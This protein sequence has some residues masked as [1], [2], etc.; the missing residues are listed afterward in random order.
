VLLTSMILWMALKGPRM[1][2]EVKSKVDQAT[3][4]GAAVGL[5]VFA[6]VVVFREGL[7][8]VLFLTPFAGG[9]PAGTVVGAI[10]G[11]FASLAISYLIFKAGVRVNLKRFFYVTSVLL[12]FVA[13]GLAGYGVHELIEH[14]EEVGASAGWFGATAFDLGIPS[15]SLMGDHG[16]IGSILA[17]MFGYSVKMEWGRVIVQLAYLAVF[18]PLTVAVYRRPELFTEMGKMLRKGAALESDN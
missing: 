5:V 7:E 6:F 3:I 18:V 1:Q 11:V 4:K 10:I 8:T 12:I 14:Q 16:A 13:A 17:V 2:E 9:E 15:G